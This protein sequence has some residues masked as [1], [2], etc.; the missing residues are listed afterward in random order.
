MN[1]VPQPWDY[2]I[3]TASNDAQAQAYESQLRLRRELGLL[4]QARE[5]LVVADPEGRR[6]GSGGS[7]LHCLASIVN[8]EL[9]RRPE[10][11]PDDQTPE[12]ILRR[13]R[14]LIVHAGGDSKRLPAYGP[15]GKIFLPLPGESYSALGA[16]LFDRVVSILLD[17][18]TG[19]TGAGQIVVASGD[20][21]L[22]F[23]REAVHF[24]SQGMTALGNYAT[25]EEASRHGVFCVSGDGSLRLYLQKPSPEEQQRR[26]AVDR[27]GRAVLDLGL[28][29]LEAATAAAW[30]RA[31]QMGF[32]ADGK[33]GW[34]GAMREAILSQ[35]LDLYREICCAMGTEVTAEQYVMA[36]NSSGSAWT[37][38]ALAALFPAL[39]E[40]P[41]TVRV[42]PRSSFLHFGATRQLTPSGLALL[43][44]DQAA[45]PAFSRLCLDDDIGEGAEITGSNAWIEGCRLSAPLALGGG[46][47]VIGVDVREPLTLPAEA[48]LDVLAGSDRAGNPVWFVRCYGAR[49]AFKDTVGSGAQFCG[50][51]LLA[52]LAVA[53]ASPED[54]WSGNAPP[55]SRNLWDARVFP[56]EEQ[57]QGYRRWLWM[58][59]PASAT[60]EQK[61]AWLA[62]DRYSA[63]EIAL[64]GD[65]NAFHLRRA[66]LRAQE[67]R[68]SLRR[69]YSR[70]STFSA[71]DLGYALWHSSDR[72]AWVVELLA[73]ARWH[74]EENGAGD[75]LEDFTFGRIV[76]SLGSALDRLF[77]SEAAALE[78]AVPGLAQRIPPDLAG[79]L[80][81]RDL[82]VNEDT[83]LGDWSRRLREAAFHQL[84]Q[85]ILRSSL[86]SKERP[87]NALRPDET[88]WGRAP[89][90]I[91]LGGGWTDTPPY[92]L[93]Y[94]GDVINAAVNL[95]GQPPIH[96]YCR[97]IEEPVIR[98]SS[99]DVGRHL[100]ITEL[101]EL[102]DYRRP[103]DSFA[104]AK[105]ALAV[106]G[107]SPELTPWPRGVTLRDMLEEF[108]GGLELTTLVGIPKGSGLGTSSILG[109]VILAVIE[110]AMG[111]TLTERELFHDVLRLEQ[112]LT[113]GGGWQDQIGG[114]VGGTKL[115][116]T[117]RGLFVD[118]RIRYVPNDLIDPK[119]NGGR[120]LLYYTG[121]TRLAKN[122]LAQIVGS[123]FNRNRSIMTTLAHEHLVARAVADAMDR[124]DARMF[125]YYVD[126]A[127]RLQ[128]QLCGEVTS[129][130][131]ES[132]LGRVRPHVHGMRISGAGSGGFLFMIAK[133]PDDAARVREMLERE[134][135][136]E[137]SRFFDFEINHAGLEVTTC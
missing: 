68:R 7:T 47:V 87:R 72:A 12:R 83:R 124:K 73:E 128:K 19:E 67:I 79:W 96:C 114:G 117:R 120:T 105:A 33:F 122:I 103:G 69:M 115:T 125:G 131:I 54:V 104:L 71:E 121:L 23:D 55:E 62:A 46:N 102:L 53:G 28:M 38:Q 81:A 3:V 6:V 112:A 18:P 76:H 75:G 127:W 39:H 4:S 34:S 91:E 50:K 65:Q 15:W 129:E 107:F 44:H 5:V 132:L 59:D 88:V 10:T 90:R 89:A 9:E 60:A 99:I 116:S 123:Y 1:R 110:R 2:L 35:G 92:T 133:S 85:T 77:G 31:F 32:G 97:V 57:H 49:D 95:N 80:G 119:M 93:E 86:T 20:A 118:P 14:V 130:A 135:L 8:L 58:F 137:R 134:P 25:V 100:Q 61:Q 113:T 26:G 16:T 78:Q 29:S 43:Q 66:A 24:A 108:G 74:F 22:L 27:C 82:G 45:P 21:L 42:L 101:E 51:P 84:N 106:S 64:L 36:A 126:V 70:E 40:I 56:A 30:C 136:N 48:C 94:G 52:W 17:L 63:A 111:R 37:E 13:L 98:L 41:M 109:A 11:R